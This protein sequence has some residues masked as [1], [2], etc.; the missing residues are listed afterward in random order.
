MVPETGS[1]FG[2]VTVLGESLEPNRR[3]GV[4]VHVRCDCGT[5]F[6]VYARQ[7]REERTRSC[8]CLR[9][10]L[11]SARA[12]RHGHATGK[13]ISPEFRVWTGAKTRC[14]N[15]RAPSWPRYGGRGITMCDR[16]RDSFAAFLADMGERPSPDHS[17]DRIDNDGPYSPG[18]CRWATREQQGGN[19]RNSRTIEHGGERLSLHAWSKRVGV[20]YSTILWRADNGWSEQEILFGRHHAAS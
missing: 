13:G 20:K 6:V 2:R 8:G 7:L 14:F 10:E 3:V 19:K 5:E 1:R 18:N 9:L 17:L 11:S 15:D 4:W 16:W 12:M